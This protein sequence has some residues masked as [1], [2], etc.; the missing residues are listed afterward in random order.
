M[1]TADTGIA[2]WTIAAASIAAAASFATLTAI[3]SRDS[4][5][6]KV[7][8]NWAGASANS[9]NPSANALLLIAGGVGP[10][11]SIELHAKILKNTITAGDDQSHLD[12]LHVSCPAR[13]SDRTGFICGGAGPNPG[14]QLADLVAEAV[15]ATR[16]NHPSRRIIIGVPCVTFHARMIFDAFEARLISSFESTGE[17]SKVV[18]INLIDSI[19]ATFAADDD[20]KRVC[21]LGTHGTVKGGTLFASLAEH[22]LDPALPDTETQALLHESIYN[23]SWGL[24]SKSRVT[25]KARTNLMQVLRN[26][27]NRG[28]QIGQPIDAFLLACTELS[29]GVP[30][31]FYDGVPIYDALN[32]LSRTMVAAVDPAKL[33]PLVEGV[34]DWRGLYASPQPND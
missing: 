17:G 31:T 20:I 19:C 8:V 26:A 27:V 18:L 23:T 29:F 30:V 12:V 2:P 3:R 24:K 4:K 32:M 15:L 9:V 10:R 16:A 1:P 7:L 14:E 21:V 33:E 22:G 11:A 34:R 13:V 28:K 5:K 25:E 6:R